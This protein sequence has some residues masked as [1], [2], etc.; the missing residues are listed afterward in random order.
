MEPNPSPVDGGEQLTDDTGACEGFGFDPDAVGAAEHPE[1]NR[2]VAS[3]A[4]ATP[5]RRT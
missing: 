5:V 4:D 3:A 2:V 1:I